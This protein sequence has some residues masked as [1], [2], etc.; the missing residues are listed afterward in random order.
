MQQGERRNAGDAVLAI[1]RCAHDAHPLPQREK[2]KAAKAIV[3]AATKARFAIYDGWH[4]CDEREKNPAFDAACKA[5]EKAI[6]DY[7]ALVDQFNAAAGFDDPKP[8]KSMS[9]DEFARILGRDDFVDHVLGLV[10]QMSVEERRRFLQALA[11]K[12]PAELDA[13]AA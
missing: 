6:A 3:K 12:Y 1:A 11:A 8:A 13:R 2:V 5:E 7:N 9:K 10:D 4:P